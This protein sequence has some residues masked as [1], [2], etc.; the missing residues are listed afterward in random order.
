[1]KAY[2]EINGARLQ[3]EM[4]G[5]GRTVVLVHGEMLDM[6]TW[7]AVFA[8]LTGRFRVLRYDRRGHGAS[9]LPLQP[10]SHAD[11]LFGLM[12]RL[13][14][15]KACVVGHSV[16]AAIALELALAHPDR[17]TGLVPMAPFLRGHSHGQAHQARL[18]RIQAVA[19]QH[20][21]GRARQIW[22]ERDPL[23]DPLRGKTALEARIAE[24]AQGHG[25]VD[26]LRPPMERIPQPGFM[27]RLYELT[28]PALV[29][30]G[31]LDAP[32][33]R[34]AAGALHAAI[35]SARTTVVPAAGHYLM[36][37]QPEAVNWILSDF[38]TGLPA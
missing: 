31:E 26:V 30:V 8:A 16:G 1:M 2:E 29:V 5:Q 14:V 20:G 12:D 7:D 18:D 9:D 23:F 27:P 37:E 4:A 19:R 32:D 13:G 28:A 10:Y 25:F 24:I 17:V 6:R 36:L 22:L 15:E 38:L 11:D 33:I 3:Y 35:P 21:A 34:A